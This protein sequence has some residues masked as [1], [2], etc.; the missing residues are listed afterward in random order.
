MPEYRFYL[1][2][3]GGHVAGPPVEFQGPDD[4]TAAK[5][6]VGYLRKGRDI[7]VWQAERVVAFLNYEEV[8]ATL[9]SGRA[10]TFRSYHLLDGEA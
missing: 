3:E 1:I 2:T 7:E 6:A 10:A 9:T 5:M 4:A 8:K